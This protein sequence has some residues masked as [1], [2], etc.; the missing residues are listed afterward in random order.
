MSIQ[1]ENMQAYEQLL[2]IFL[3]EAEELFG[4]KND[5]TFI[6]IGYHNHPPRMYMFDKD[7]FSGEE[8]YKIDL[9]GVGAINDRKDGIFQLSHEVVHLLSPVPQD[10]DENDV[11]RVN[12]LEE[13]MATYF[14]KCVTER[15]TADY[16][17]CNNAML[18]DEKYFT[19]YMRYQS[20]QEIDTEAVKKLRTIQPIIP[21]IQAED[22][23][24]AGLDVPQ[25]LINALLEKFPE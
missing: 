21:L 4:P 3:A 5:Y 22:F 7:P 19:A 2:P 20:L 1:E 15:E 17:F 6:G 25:N 12:Y 16:D 18:K 14:A 9:Y 13:G 8:Y 11:N 10:T 23:V 24:A